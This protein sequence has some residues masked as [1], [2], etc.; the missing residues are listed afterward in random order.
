MQGKDKKSI[1]EKLKKVL[2][3][4]AG[5]AGT[6]EGE[7][8]AKKANDLMTKHAIKMVEISDESETIGKLR[9]EIGHSTWKRRLLHSVAGYCNCSN[10]YTAASSQGALVGY[11]A[12][13]EV[14]EYLFGIISD[15]TLRKSKA[16]TRRLKWC[17]KGQKRKAGNDFRLS[18]VEGFKDKLKALK[19]NAATLDQ[20]GTAIMVNRKAEVRDWVKAN[21]K[22]YSGRTSTSSEYNSAGYKCGQ[23]ATLH[24]GISGGTTAKIGG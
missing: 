15:E 20:T 6:P 21:L 1:I 19:D 9:L 17:D 16:Y 10:Y 5:E 18:A 7:L 14:A 3:L 13:V 2:A 8:A 24:T 11:G 12:D 23:N 4:A 22:L